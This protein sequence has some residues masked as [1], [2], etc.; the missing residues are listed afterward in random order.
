MAEAARLAGLS[1]RTVHRRLEEEGFRREVAHYRDRL[2][3]AGVGALA[4]AVREAVEVLQELQRSAESEHVRVRAARAILAHLPVLREHGELAE[5][6]DELEARLEGLN[7]S[8]T[9]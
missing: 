7:G 6:L 3:D 8:E 1:E 9:A 2:V 5:R 4:E